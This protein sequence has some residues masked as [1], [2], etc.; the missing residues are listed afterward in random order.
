MRRTPYHQ[1]FAAGELSEELWGLVGDAKNASGL[2]LCKNFITMPHGPIVNRSG[3]RYV[4]HAGAQNP[5]DVVRLIPFVYSDTQSAVLEVGP[6]YIRVHTAGATLLTAP[7]S[8][9]SIATP[10]ASAHI[11]ELAHEQS[12]DVVTFAHRG[13]PPANLTRR[14]AASWTYAAVNFGASV[15]AP[16][17]TSAIATAGSTPGAT[18]QHRYVV[19][20]V[21]DASESPAST[22]VSTMNNLLDTGASNRISWASVSGADSYRVYKFSGGVY[23]YIGTA[24]ETRFVDDNIIPDISRTPPRYSGNLFE[25]GYPSAVARYEQRVWFAGLA[26]DPQRV[27]ATRAGS[28]S[29]MSYTIP[30]Q[31]SNALDFRPATRDAS[32]IRHLVPVGRLLAF[33]GSAEW[34]IDSATEVMTPTSIAVRPQSYVG[35]GWPRPVIVNSTVVFAAARGGHMRELGYSNDHGGYVTGDLSLRAHH[36]FDDATIVDLTYAKA[37]V[38]I[39]WAASSTGNLLGMTYVPE[40]AIAGWHWHDLGGIVESVAAVPEGNVDALYLVVRREIA[41][42][43]VRTVERMAGRRPGVEAYHVD[44]GATYVGAPKQRI[45]GLTWLEGAEVAVLA[46]G[47]V[48]PRCKVSGGSIALD[49]PAQTVQVGLPIEAEAR[50]LPM[51][52]GEN[53]AINS[54]RIRVRRSAGIWVGQ[55]GGKLAE[56]R[57]RAREPWGTAPDEESGEIEV[58]TP[59]AGFEPGAQWR[60][61]QKDPLP[62]TVISALADVA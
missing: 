38:P 37:P 24:S 40:Q 14:G 7:G 55:V 5:S 49:H 10:Y 45:S 47:A 60:I 36:L 28:E 4:A 3:T 32:A 8:P 6:R 43:Q 9:L 20:A 39:V 50:S 53:A 57:G 31:D 23:G 13:Y 25:R 30:S 11:R 41:G 26:M 52:Y 62:L 44:C 18:T 34:R 17:W 59:S 35:S 12:N 19:T 61:V 33:T 16:A 27:L 2:A 15:G 21:L 29:D 46:D 54:L 58:V 51:A 42:R 48:H 1:S 56:H 22:Q